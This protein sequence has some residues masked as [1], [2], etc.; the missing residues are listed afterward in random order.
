MLH[1]PNPEWSQL[2]AP[3]REIQQC[4]QRVADKYKVRRFMKF[5]HKCLGAVWNEE[6]GKWRVEIEGPAG[7]I[8][9]ECY[10]LI[11]ATGILNYWKWPDIPGI[12]EFKG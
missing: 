5:N 7:T 8:H 2:Y 6:T 10:V 1:E 4:L 9:D 11:N 3:G 12:H